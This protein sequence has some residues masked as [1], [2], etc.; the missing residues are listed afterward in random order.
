VED[1]KEM[2][3]KRIEEKRKLKAKF[4]ADYDESGGKS[5]Y[6]DLKKEV[7]AQA[8]VRITKFNCLLVNT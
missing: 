7:D 4:D 8:Q 2:R 5:H 6:E 3:K 1:E